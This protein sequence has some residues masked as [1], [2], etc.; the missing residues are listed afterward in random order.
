MQNK[1]YLIRAA[2]KKSN[3]S[4]M[5]QMMQIIKRCEMSVKWLTQPL[6]NEWFKWIIKTA[7]NGCQIIKPVSSTW[8]KKK[9]LQGLP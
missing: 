2:I 7:P 4:Q 5:I 9:N 6:I 8:I 1:H 3:G